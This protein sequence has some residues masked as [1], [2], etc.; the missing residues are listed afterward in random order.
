MKT[1]NALIIGLLFCILVMS[2][3]M[4]QRAKEI[5]MDR[6]WI[7]E[8]IDDNVVNLASKGDTLS[9]SLENTY[10]LQ[11]INRVVFTNL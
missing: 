2:F 5:N 3:K 8:I 1:R 10:G 11:S 9:L 4:A 6:E 7:I